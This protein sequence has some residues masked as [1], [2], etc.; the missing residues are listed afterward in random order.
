VNKIRIEVEINNKLEVANIDLPESWEEVPKSVYPHLASLYL[1]TDKQMSVYDKTVRAFVSLTFE[2]WK[3]ISKLHPEE[4]HDLLPLIDWVFNKLDVFKN[5]LPGVVIDKKM[6]YG[7]SDGMENLR[8]LEWCAASSFAS[9]YAESENIED[10]AGLA[11]CLY[12]PAGRGEEY[13]PGTSVYRGDRREKFNDQLIAAR[14]KKMIKLKRPALQGIYVWFASCRYQ[15]INQY[16]HLTKSSAGDAK[17]GAD[18]LDV[19]D[20]LRGDPKFGGPDK[21][22]DEFLNYV[23]FSMNRNIEKMAELKSK[24]NL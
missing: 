6:F 14:S 13:I 20:D 10:L 2:H 1:A 4:L 19:Y 15:I 9:A 7:P 11:A 22:D 18:W 5:P 12:R 3:V 21:L 23:L 17:S 8:F 24:Y 16:D